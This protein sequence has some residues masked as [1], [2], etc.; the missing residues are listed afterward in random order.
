[1]SNVLV[2]GAG[3]SVKP[4]IDYLS[5]KGHKI[6]V[7]TRN[8]QRTQWLTENCAVDA[9]IH[10]DADTGFDV[11]DSILP[12]YDLVGSFIPGGYQ[13]QVAELCIRHKVP[14]VVS[15]HGEYFEKYPGGIAALDAQA[16]EAGIPVITEL[17]VD[18][19]YLGMFAAKA[20]DRVK[21]KGGRVKDLWFHAG[22]IPAD[23]TNPLDYSFFWAAKKACLSYINPKSGKADWI[24]DG[25]RIRVD[26]DNVY[27]APEIIEVPGCGVFETHPNLDSGAFSYEKIYGIEGVDNF[28]HGTLRHLGWCNVMSALINLGFSDDT[29]RS[30]TG[31]TYREIMLELCNAENAEPRKAAA[32]KLGVSE[33]DDVILRLGWLGLFDDT[34][35]QGDANSYCEIAAERIMDKLGV[36]GFNSGVGSR[37]INYFEL[38][39]SYPEG[40]EKTISV[41]DYSDEGEGNSLSSI[42]IST[43]TAIVADRLLQKDMQLTGFQYPYR[44]EI[45]DVV[46][47]E[48][49]RMGFR[50]HE[51]VVGTQDTPDTSPGNPGRYEAANSAVVA[52]Q[53]V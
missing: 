38:L 14:L 3:L 22:V 8:L 41:F 27:S 39:A 29:P 25:E 52:A 28:Y 12:E 40:E 17:G 13:P 26:A 30:N 51:Q 20:I 32:A 11:L 36:H 46:L 1:M 10:F 2:L 16:K 18:C 50:N 15:C 23:C 42:L 4:F 24:R 48:Y 19:G 35:V 49:E 44:P 53:A 37:V 7:A 9:N 31:V 45:Y 33:Y 34:P 5:D 43:T 21:A 47:G 6:T